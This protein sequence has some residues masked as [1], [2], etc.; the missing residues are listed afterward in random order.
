[1]GQLFRLA[2]AVLTDEIDFVF[3]VEVRD[4]CDFRAV[5]RPTSPFVV[6][7]R[8]VG[9]IASGSFFDGRGENIPA[10]DKE[11]AF[12]FGTEAEVLNLFGRGNLRRPHRYAV[13]RDFDR[14]VASLAGGSIKDVQLA[15]QFIDNLILVVRA[16]PAKIPLGAMRELFGLF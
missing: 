3:A 15:V 11:S 13:V 12:T 2:G 10:G 6:R 7:I 5:W 4:E 1:M 9:E 8:G 16:W 14:D